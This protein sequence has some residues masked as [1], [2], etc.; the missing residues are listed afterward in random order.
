MI[1]PPPEPGLVQRIVHIAG[2]GGGVG[3]TTVSAL[4][5]A[6]HETDSAPMLLDHSGGSLGARLTGGDE[7]AAVDPTVTLHDA[8]PHADGILIDL[9]A[10]PTEF[11]MIVTSDTPA[12]IAAA[13]RTLDRID[14]RPGTAGLARTITVA[15]ANAG[16]HRSTGFAALGV[17]YGHHRTAQIPADP[18][19]AIGGRIPVNRLAPRTVRAQQQLRHA[20]QERLR[21]YAAPR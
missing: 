12:G 6:A 15:V 18:A 8:G 3:T 21:G 13:R 9:L 19:L 14:E 7:V 5:F 17:D 2:T 1:T 11:A 4:L 10:Y 16:R 20:L